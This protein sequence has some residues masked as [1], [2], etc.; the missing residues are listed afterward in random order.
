MN[1]LLLGLWMFTAMLYQDQRLPP[2]DPNLKLT[3]EFRDNGTSRLA[4]NFGAAGARCEREGLWTVVGENLLRDQVT[5]VNPANHA[6]CSDDPDMA[7]SRV[8]VTPFAIVGEE[9]H[10]RL[11][12]GPEELVY[13]WTH[14][15]ENLPR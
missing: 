1:S 11:S 14:T 15:K 7:M 10:L 2:R 6:T 8:T 5:W 12:F 9:F 4:W 13:V 3:Y